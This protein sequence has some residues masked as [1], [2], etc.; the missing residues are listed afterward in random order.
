MT[1]TDSQVSEN[2][3]SA[4]LGF[5][6]KHSLGLLGI[7]SKME[8]G[9]LSITHV[10]EDE[11][12]VLIVVS[13]V[14]IQQPDDVWMIAEVLEEHNLPEGA[15]GIR[16]IAEGVEDFL[17]SHHTSALPVHR[18]PHYPISLH[19]QLKNKLILNQSIALSYKPMQY[20]SIPA[21]NSIVNCIPSPQSN[22]RDF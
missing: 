10:L 6:L 1:T 15:L 13:A 19:H 11:I 4:G 21:G 7:L 8:N 14:Y 16:L 22:D 3:H 20:L 9:E 12:D 18:F 17:D 2:F 5:S